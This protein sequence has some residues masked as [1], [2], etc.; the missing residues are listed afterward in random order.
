MFRGINIK[1]D[2]CGKYKIDIKLLKKVGFNN[3]MISYDKNAFKLIKEAKLNDI[4]ISA[5]HLPYKKYVNYIWEN[6]ENTLIYKNLLIEAIEFANNHQINKVIM[7]ITSGNEP[8][9]MNICAINFINE[10]LIYCE[11]YKI[12]LCLENLRRLDY[13]DYVLSNCKNDYLAICL[14]TGHINAFTRNSYNFPWENFLNKVQCIHM[15]DN[16]GVDDQHLLPFDGNIPWNIFLQELK[17]YNLNDSIYLEIYSGAKSKYDCSDELFYEI[18]MNRLN[19][20]MNFIKGVSHEN[21][22]NH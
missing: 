5:L 15:H 21:R 22:R 6:N 7:H 17:K 2:E 16:N 19:I 13:L 3:L 8:P 12:F 4:Q 11:K 9:L 14:D 20:I 10:L 1:Y 18:C